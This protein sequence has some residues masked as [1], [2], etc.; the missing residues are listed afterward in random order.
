MRGDEC[1]RAL[2]VRAVCLELDAGRADHDAALAAAGI[3]PVALCGLAELHRRG[4]DGAALGLVLRR[5]GGH[6]DFAQVARR[7]RLRRERE[8]REDGK[9]GEQLAQHDAAEIGQ[10]G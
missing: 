1:A 3:H 5:A 7:D 4:D 10:A 8:A 9:Q 2:F 6:A